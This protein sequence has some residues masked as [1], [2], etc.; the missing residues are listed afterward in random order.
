[1][2]PDGRWL[3]AG[4]YDGSLTIYDARTYKPTREPMIVFHAYQPATGN[5]AKEAARR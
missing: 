2:S 1:M 5:D 3:A 4:R